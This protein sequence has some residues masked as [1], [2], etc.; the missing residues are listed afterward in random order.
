MLTKILAASALS[1]ALATSVMAQ[2]S[3]NSGSGSNSNSGSG[4]S[5]GSTSNNGSGGDAGNGNNAGTSGNSGSANTGN[6]A[7]SNDKGKASD[8]NGMSTQTNTTAMKQDKTRG[9]IG[10]AIHVKHTLAAAT[11]AAA[12]PV[13]AMT[14]TTTP[15]EDR[16]DVA[17]A[18]H[19]RSFANIHGL[20]LASARELIISCKGDRRAADEAAI[21]F[22]AHFKQ[23]I[24]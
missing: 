17:N 24:K 1:L 13:R 7:G 10:E 23:S 20:T 15:Y 18:E 5:S 2:S 19:V 22:K 21:A 6:A 11:A 3:S 9:F 4:T 12:S 14:K 8:C 16:I